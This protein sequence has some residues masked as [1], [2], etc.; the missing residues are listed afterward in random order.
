MHVCERWCMWGG[1]KGNKRPWKGGKFWLDVTKKLLISLLAENAM[2]SLQSNCIYCRGIKGTFMY[3]VSSFNPFSALFSDYPAKSTIR[4]WWALFLG[5]CHE[6]NRHVECA[7][8]PLVSPLRITNVRVRLDY[9]R[10]LFS[11]WDSWFYQSTC[12]TLTEW[13]WSLHP[14]PS[15]ISLASGLCPWRWQRSGEEIS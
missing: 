8:W 11:N 3:R 6:N 14:P 15:A 4:V 2:R 1:R 10:S 13:A 12:P 9:Q 7:F 5:L